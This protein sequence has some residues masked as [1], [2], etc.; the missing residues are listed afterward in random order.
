MPSIPQLTSAIQTMLPDVAQQAAAQTG[1]VRRQR[2]ISG[3]QFVQT[4]V[5]G[6]LADPA[7][8]YESLVSLATDLGVSITPQGLCDRFTAAAGACLEQVLFKLWKQ[9]GRLDAS[10][11]TQ[12]KRVV[13]ELYAKFIGLLLQHWLMLAG[14]WTLPNRSLVKAARVVRAWAARIARAL[15]CSE[16]LRQTLSATIAAINRAAR[17]AYRRKQP[18]TRQLL[19]GAFAGLT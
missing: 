12:P 10:R 6:W 18:G 3:A 13:C 4:L 16:R 9:H 2:A 11:G 7:A 17:Q 15:Q 8:D 5:C 1:F 19:G 14:C